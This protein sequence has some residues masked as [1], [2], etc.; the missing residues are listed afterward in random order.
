[1]K[2][3]GKKYN[4]N[5]LK[6]EIKNIKTAISK[7]YETSYSFINVLTDAS[8]HKAVI[9]LSKKYIKVKN[10]VV[11]G[12]GGSNLGVK[13]VYEALYGNIANEIRDKKLYFADTVD[14][15]ATE[16]IL[17]IVKKDPAN[18]LCIVISKSGDTLETITNFETFFGFR[19]TKYVAISD[20]NSV[21][22]KYAEMHKIPVLEIPALVGG[23]YSIFSPV[24]LF[25]LAVLG[26]DIGAF[27]K[28]A[29]NIKKKSLSLF[30][31]Y[32]A[33]SALQIY[34]S[35]KRILELFA[36]STYFESLGKW[37]R[38]LTAESLGKRIDRLGKDV[39]DGVTPTVAIGS[40]DLHSMGQL[41]FGGPKD[42]FISFIIPKDRLTLRI[43]SKTNILPILHKKKY[44]DIIESIFYGFEKELIAYRIP[45]NVVHIKRHPYDIGE[46]MMFKM[47]ET[48][49][50][51]YLMNV[52]PF[53]QP[54]VEEYK[55][56]ARAKLE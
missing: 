54:S 46:W 30:S 49:F 23:R 5:I 17:N 37:S 41:Y 51:G 56:T 8:M 47:F 42:K 43:H 10:I 11:I 12:I 4:I 22:W 26:I 35:N 6:P 53:D 45:Y 15:I 38:Q 7:K 55:K 2:Y 19:N 27:I 32:A 13:A 14:S 36:F 52:N 24:G 39:W 25:P 50:L 16:N 44:S 20:K 40:T 28:G 29:L 21:L 34:N 9:E 48:I 3:T 18:T 33:Q 31:N 1:M